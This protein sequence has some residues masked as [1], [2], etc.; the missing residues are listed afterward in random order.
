MTTYLDLY[1]S[2]YCVFLAWFGLASPHLASPCRWCFFYDSLV[3][4]N[5]YCMLFTPLHP[6]LCLVSWRRPSPYNAIFER[7]IYWYI[8]WLVALYNCDDSCWNFPSAVRHKHLLFSARMLFPSQEHRFRSSISWA[9]S[10][11][12]I[13]Q[14]VW[15]VWVCLLC[16]ETAAVPY[17]CMWWTSQ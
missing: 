17:E 4:S 8:R 13:F 14:I 2:T 15:C 16:D 12:V 11:V 9:I 7:Q 10:F 1:T 3:F 5:I 6:I